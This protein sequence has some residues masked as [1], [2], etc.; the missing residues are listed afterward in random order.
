M[1]VLYWNLFCLPDPA[2]LVSVVMEAAELPVQL[3]P[4]DAAELFCHLLARN[5]RAGYV[6][7][8]DDWLHV[9]GVVDDAVVRYVAH[10]LRH[11]P[12]VL[13]EGSGH[14]PVHAV[15]DP[16][17]VGLC[18]LHQV[19]FPVPRLQ[20]SQYLA[21]RHKDL[22]VRV[23]ERPIR[24]GLPAPHQVPLA[25]KLLR[26][27][28]VEDQVALLRVDELCAIVADSLECAVP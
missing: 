26:L 27:E 16:L 12:V 2:H 17:H 20:R 5:P 6:D 13:I 8:V 4:N 22:A 9:P 18:L 3:L 28:M 21:I 14:E 23:D 25:E 11:L 15:G 10:H 7:V 24:I 1:A 19:V